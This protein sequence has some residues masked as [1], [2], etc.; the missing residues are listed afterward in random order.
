MPHKTV[1]PSTALVNLIDTDTQHGKTT[2]AIV[3]ETVCTKRDLL[4]HLQHACKVPRPMQKNFSI[5][6]VS[7]GYLFVQD[8]SQVFWN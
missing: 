4:G 6:F 8:H 7:I 5:I 1:G 2:V 3:D